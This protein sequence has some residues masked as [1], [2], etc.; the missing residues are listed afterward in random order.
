MKPKT[1]YLRFTSNVRDKLLLKILSVALVIIILLPIAFARIGI[2]GRP[3]LLRNVDIR[4]GYANGCP[5]GNAT[6]AAMIAN[7]QLAFSPRLTRRLN[8]EYSPGSKEDLLIKEL[9]NEGFFEMPPCNT[10][11]TIRRASYE[12]GSFFTGGKIIATIYWKTSVD[13]AIVWIGGIVSYDGF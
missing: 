2:Y 8:Q 11:N 3:H 5:P 10:D 6:E 7:S 1:F 9:L 4:G 13:G 12:G